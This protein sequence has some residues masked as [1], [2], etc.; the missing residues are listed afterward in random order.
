SWTLLFGIPEH[1]A[2][3]DYG[4]D[5]LGV[6]NLVNLFPEVVYINVDDVGSKVKVDPPDVLEDIDPGQHFIFVV[7]KIM[8]QPVFRRGQGYGLVPMQQRFRVVIQ[9]QVA[10]AQQVGLTLLGNVRGLPGP[11]EQ[12]FDPRCQFDKLKGLYQVIVRPGVKAKYDVFRSPQC[13]KKKNRDLF[14]PGTDVFAN[15]QAV[16]LGK[17]NIENDQVKR[18]FIKQ[19]KSVFA[20]KSDTYLIAYFAKSFVNKRYD[21]GLVFYEQ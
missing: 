17:H 19:L 4:M 6:G 3:A 5:I 15:F 9:R 10:D 8:D 13:R 12:G 2:H 16:H 20:I 1:V 21:V 7:Q 11:A 18:T 14:V